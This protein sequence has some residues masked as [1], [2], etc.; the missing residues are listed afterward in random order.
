[1]DLV[2]CF[3]TSESHSALTTSKVRTTFPQLKISGKVSLA[4]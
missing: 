2:S 3:V 4:S 1:M